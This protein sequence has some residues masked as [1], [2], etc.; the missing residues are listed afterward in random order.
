MNQNGL[1]GSQYGCLCDNALT[2]R[3]IRRD[4]IHDIHHDAFHNGTEASGSCLYFHCHIGNGF[5]GIVLK[6]QLNIVKV[7]QLPVL[8]DQSVPRLL[9]NSYQCIPVE[10]LQGNNNRNTT[11]KFR[12]QSA[13]HQ[14]LRNQF[15]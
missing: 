4:G 8:L 12:D 7:E 3:L 14:I 15:L 6:E 10:A 13:L 2:N 1:L 9:Q 11:D 5:N